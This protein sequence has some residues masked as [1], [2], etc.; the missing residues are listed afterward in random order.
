MFCVSAAGDMLPPMTIF[1][2][3]TGIVYRNWCESGQDGASY[4]ATKSGWF[5]MGK[6]DQWFRE[7]FLVWIRRFPRE[8]VKVLLGDNLAAHMSPYV[9]RNC[10]KYNVRFC[11]LPENSTHLLQPLDVSVFAPMK[12]E[13]R[14]VLTQ[15][16]SDC[17]R[18][19]K[20]YSTIP[21]QI[22]PELLKQVCAKDYSAAIRSGFAGTGLFPLSLERA[23]SK[24]PEEDREVE[25][26]VQRQLLKRLSDMRYNPPPTTA[27]PRPS[28]K[29]KLPP[30]AS[31][32]CSRGKEKVGLPVGS[33]TDSSDKDGNSSDEDGNSSDSS[34]YE[35]D[36]PPVR[37]SGKSKSSSTG[38]SK[39]SRVVGVPSSSA[40]S[41]D[42]EGEKERSLQVRKIVKRLDVMRKDSRSRNQ[43]EAESG[44]PGAL[45]QKAVPQE[46]VPQ[47]AGSYLV[48]LYQGDWYLGQ[49]LDKSIEPDADPDDKYLYVNY[50]EKSKSNHFK[51]PVRLDM[52]NT[53][54]VRIFLIPVPTAEKNLFFQT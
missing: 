17:D 19:G 21:K 13:W 18:A 33:D 31:Y 51:W 8:E 25:T 3:A 6:F 32:T 9:L 14:A 54:K 11:F 29:D 20:N 41:E 46:A 7:V 44:P 5:D 4:G 39:K 16:K 15:W 23:L 27:A 53:L 47:E 42:S 26:E 43:Q 22:F 1:K 48:A 2:S 37:P 40:S 34:S 45:P 38:T 52:L 49:I 36:E 24:L 35:A 28:K 12:K 10:T 30:G 50:M